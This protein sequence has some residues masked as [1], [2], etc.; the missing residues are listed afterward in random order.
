MKKRLYI[1][2]STKLEWK[3]Y[4][5]QHPPVGAVYDEHRQSWMTAEILGQLQDLRRSLE[6]GRML[7]EMS[8]QR[9]RQHKRILN[10]C[11]L[12]FMEASIEVILKK[13][14]TPAMRDAYFSITDEL[15]TDTPRRSK[16]A[17]SPPKRAASSTN[18]RSRNG[19]MDVD[20]TRT[21]PR[22]S[23]RVAADE[24][25]SPATRARK[26]QSS[27][28][29]TT[30]KSKRRRLVLDIEPETESPSSEISVVEGPSK[31]SA[32]RRK[33]ETGDAQVANEARGT[34][35]RGMSPAE[36]KRR[37]VNCLDRA[38]QPS[39]FDDVVEENFPELVRALL[40]AISSSHRAKLTLC[41]C[42]ACLQME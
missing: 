15:L 22:R 28:S 9:D 23:S 21:P 10:L 25:D 36:L 41:L 32:T 7:L 14:P 2:K 42:V 30:E 5:E 34:R 4:C 26:R 19:N 20:E 16:S 38:T 33:I 31:R 39:D 8:R 13:R 24:S 18:A 40:T 3:F 35:E 6:R 29:Q 12:P 27:V 1:A 11:K 17:A 37:F